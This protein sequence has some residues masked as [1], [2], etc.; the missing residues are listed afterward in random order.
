MKTEKSLGMFLTVLFGVLG[1]TVLMLAWLWP[2]SPSDR[3][4]A[5]LVGS[6]SLFGA[7]IRIPILKRSQGRPDNKQA[8]VNSEFKKRP[9]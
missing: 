9:D 3:I 4:P 5:I 8:P 2:V 7:L 6:A 1:L